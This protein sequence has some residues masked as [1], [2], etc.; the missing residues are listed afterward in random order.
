[1]VILNSFE[2]IKDAYIKKGDIFSGR[3][4]GF[5][6][7]NFGLDDLGVGLEDGESW[8]EQRKF[9]INS[10][11]YL[12][13]GKTTIEDKILEECAALIDVIDKFEEKPFYVVP[14]FGNVVAN[15]SFSVLFGERFSYDNPDFVKWVK[16]AE[17]MDIVLGEMSALDFFPWISKLPER[18]NGLQAVRQLK[19]DFNRYSV[20][21]IENH[22]QTFKNDNIRDYIDYF[23]EEMYARQ[24]KEAATQDSV[25]DFPRLQ[26]NISLLI[27]AGLV[28]TSMTLS[29]IIKLLTIYPEAQKKLSDEISTAIGM[30]RQPSWSDHSNMPFTEAVILE[31]QRIGDIIPI[32]IPHSNTEEVK[33]MGYDIP[34]RSMVYTNVRKLHSDPALWGDPEKFRPE[35]FISNG[36]CVKPEYLMPFG[37][38]RRICLGEN[39]ARMNMFLVIT[40]IFQKH[41]V[42]AA[43]DIPEDHNVLD[44]IPGISRY[45]IPFDVFF[46][47]H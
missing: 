26:S 14:L 13:V 25:F 32:G 11:K 1:M 2:A 4:L 27:I 15:V 10:L 19:D 38:G 22:I 43:S 45:L 23:L 18:L 28:T 31:A 40:S 44:V 42:S 39:L 36:K 16:L 8:K 21:R 47:K 33:V 7:L 29:W 17:T 24:A 12:G 35:R 41:S 20:E 34:Q 6:R 46:K 3:P 30:E 5:K 37:A 9:I